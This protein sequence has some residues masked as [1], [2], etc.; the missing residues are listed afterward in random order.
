MPAFTY[1]GFFQISPTVASALAICGEL[2]FTLW[3]IHWS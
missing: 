2:N 1:F 3:A